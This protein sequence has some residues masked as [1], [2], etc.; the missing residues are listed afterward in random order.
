LFDE[1]V[2]IDNGQGSHRWELWGSGKTV[3]DLTNYY[4]KTEIDQQ[5]DVLEQKIIAA[6]TLTWIDI[7]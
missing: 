5:V 6:G 1:Y 3:A 7:N 4:T 2:W